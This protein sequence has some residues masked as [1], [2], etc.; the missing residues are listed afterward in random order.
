MDFKCYVCARYARECAIRFAF[1]LAT[2]ANVPSGS[3]LWQ[4]RG[5]PVR[6]Y[7]CFGSTFPF[8]LPP[9]P[10]LPKTP[11][12]FPLCARGSAAGRGQ[13]GKSARGALLSFLR[14]PVSVKRYV[15]GL[16]RILTDYLCAR[17]ARECAI[18]FAFALATLASVPSGLRGDAGAGVARLRVPTARECSLGARWV[19]VTALNP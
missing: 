17:Y 8:P 1:A 19:L 16:L 18:R 6:F 12:P 3:R 14:L 9:L 5:E 10:S 11:P 15:N 13:S 4:A 2:L 7:S